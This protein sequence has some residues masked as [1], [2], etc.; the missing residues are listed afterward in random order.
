MAFPQHRR[1]RRYQA[2]RKIAGERRAHVDPSYYTL[3]LPVVGGMI[4][5]GLGTTSFSAHPAAEA[6][7]KEKKPAYS[8]RKREVLLPLG[9]ISFERAAAAAAVGPAAEVGEVVPASPSLL[10]GRGQG[11]GGDNGW[12][13]GIL[14]YGYRVLALSVSSQK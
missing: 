11:G 9:G 3:P 10:D 7:A 2:S 14:G 13:E 6:V 4:N 1:Q 8:R 5:H 12:K